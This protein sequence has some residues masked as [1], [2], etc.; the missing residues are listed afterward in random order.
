[1]E[2]DIETAFKVR[3]HYKEILI[4]MPIT[5]NSVY[6][7]DGIFVCHKGNV[8]KALD[9]LMANNFDDKYPLIAVK[10]DSQKFQVFVYMY[11]GANI[12]Y[13]ELDANLTEKGI[14]KIY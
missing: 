5:P 8:H 13:D 3:N 6:K 10:N 1:M 11:D 7:I 2:F 4:G 14:E 9:I 12:A